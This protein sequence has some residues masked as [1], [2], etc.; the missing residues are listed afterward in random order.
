[1]QRL[2]GLLIESLIPTAVQKEGKLI[3]LEQVTKWLFF[4]AAENGCKVD[5]SR[6]LSSTRFQQEEASE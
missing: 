4:V 5:H 1:L 6:H 2:Q 3:D